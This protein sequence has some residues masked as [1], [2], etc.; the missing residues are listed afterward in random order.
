[1][2]QLDSGDVD[3]TNLAIGEMERMKL[4]PNLIVSSVSS[5][6]LTN[7][8]INMTRPYFQDK[9]VRQA[10]WYAIDR[11]GIVDSIFAGQARVVNSPIFGPAWMGEPQVNPYAYD[12]D[13]AKALLEEVGWDPNQKIELMGKAGGT[14]E[15][16][17][18]T[19]VIQNQLQAIGMDVEVILADT[20]VVQERFVAKADYDMRDNGGGMYGAEPANGAVYFHSQQHMPAGLNYSRYS[21]PQL[22]E[23]IDSGLVTS[24]QAE[25]KEIYT[26]VARVINEEA[27]TVFLWV[28]NS[29]CA[30]NKRLQGF[31]PT[32]YLDNYLWNAEEWSIES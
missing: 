17:A 9:R 4:N 20:A 5:P 31:K 25:R 19:P 15:Q 29:V 6:S 2:A 14:K 27:P 16:A 3:Y 1:M 18:Y 22:D 30:Y 8:A 23:L 21:N 28:P 32:S 26:E 10:M 12:P 7:L 11:Q 13:K 24:D